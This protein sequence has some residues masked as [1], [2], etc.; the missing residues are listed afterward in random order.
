MIEP[1]YLVRP[2]DM[3]IYVKDERNGCYRSLTYTPRY[4]D[5]TIPLAQNHFTFKNLT[6][7]YEFYPILE[8]DLEKYKILEKEYGQYEIWASRSDGHGG[9]KGGTFE[10]YK[11][12]IK[13]NTL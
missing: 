2:T 11:L 5:G 3:M 1:K 7:N 13:Q 4:E 9:S 8:E 10:E 6:E 12:K